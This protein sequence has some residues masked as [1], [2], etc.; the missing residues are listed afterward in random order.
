MTFT[1][2]NKA[3]RNEA[4]TRAEHIDPRLE[5]DGW[6]HDGNSLIPWRSRESA[7]LISESFMRESDYAPC[8]ITA[9]ILKVPLPDA[10]SRE[11]HAKIYS[12]CQAS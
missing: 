9:G 4:E 2:K 5:Y 3:N 6:N 1:P 10:S 8:K 12:F 11:G 7:D